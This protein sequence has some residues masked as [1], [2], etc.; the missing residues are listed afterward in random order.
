MAIPLLT[1]CAA[2]PDFKTPSA[3]DVQAYSPQGLPE[4]TVE[5]DTANG[6]AQQF[7]P[8]GDIPAAWWTLFRSD[9]LNGLIIKALAANPD[10][11][12]AKA[13]LR[14]AEE[15]LYASEGAFFPSVDGNADATRQKSSSNGSSAANGHNSPFT[16]YNTSV[17]VSYPLDVFGGIRRQ[18]EGLEALKDVQRFELEAAYNSLTSNVATAAI[19]EASLRAQ[20]VATQEIA[21][22]ERKQLD[23]LKQQF[24]AGAVAKAAVLAQEAILAQSLATLPPLEKQLAQTR[25]LLAALA[26]QFPGEELG[27]AFELAEL[28][29][30]GTLP[31]S[32]PSQLVEQRPDVQ[33][34]TAQLHAASADIGVAAANMLPQI[35]LT[36]SYGIS[37]G[38]LA[39]LFAPGAAF[40]T[41]GAGLLQPLFH[42]GEL[43]HKKR[44]SEA[45]YER[46]AAQ[47]RST[48]LAAFRN[49]ADVLRALETDASS[50]K[51]QAAAERAAAESLKLAREQFNAGAINYLSLLT[52]QQT[53]EQSKIARIQAEALRFADTAALFQALGGGWWNRAPGLET[54]G[55]AAENKETTP[56]LYTGVSENAGESISTASP[57][58][59]T[60]RPEPLT[61]RN[62]GRKS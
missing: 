32:L 45:A 25:H 53:L 54:R 16:L 41:L 42:G 60:P 2:G 59:Q 37:A 6:S 14:E 38:Q 55:S 36:G 49:V 27:A 11:Q 48:V 24:E 47:Y 34:A 43:L 31:V 18:V 19:Q 4:K 52:A 44:A 3:P 57:E 7:V 23:L 17:S 22:D 10:L 33:A 39:S 50:L 20:L 28:H 29:L 40:W 51:A 5:A 13:S 62:F 56:S 35:T 30:P 58:P 9:A 15:N 61:K 26:G 21:N 46:A 8:G 1:G 12:A